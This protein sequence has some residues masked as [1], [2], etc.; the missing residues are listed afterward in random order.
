[1]EKHDINNSE[2]IKLMV[3]T[4]YD[5]VNQQTDLSAV[6]N[7]FAK[8][9]WESHLPKMYSFWSKMLLG[10]GNYN[11]RPFDPHIPLPINETHFAHW[12]RIFIQNMDEHFKGPIAESAKMRAQ[13]IAQVFQHKLAN[14][15]QNETN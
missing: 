13:N 10:E 12:L 1:M 4:F 9:N 11:G 6:F 14:F 8:V 15:H 3:D 7:D 2:D 5:K